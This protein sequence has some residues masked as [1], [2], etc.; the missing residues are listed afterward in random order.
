MKISP[1]QEEEIRETWNSETGNEVTQFG[2]KL[3][4]TREEQFRLAYIQKKGWEA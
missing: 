2:W 4:T 1:E 3:R